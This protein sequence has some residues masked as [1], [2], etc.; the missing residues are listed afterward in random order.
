MA[1]RDE[2]LRALA[3]QLVRSPTAAALAVEVDSLDLERLSVPDTR[4]CR[5]AE[6]VCRAACSRSLAAHCFR[7]YAWAALL[8][9]GLEWD[10]EMLYT[11]AI[12]HDLGL[13]PDYDRGGCF[14]SDGAYAAREI[15]TAVGWT[16]PRLDTVAEAVYLHMH[17]VTSAHSAEARLLA[18]GTAADVTGRRIL[19]LPEG[20]RRFVLEMF[21]RAGFKQEL[22]VRFTEQA[23]WK[24]RCVIYE[25]M[26]NGLAD[27][28]AAAPFDE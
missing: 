12:L 20:T 8:G 7:S 10:E 22:I 24:P 19:E 6:R 4:A 5:E 16:S 18:A 21:P 2:T 17:E 11:A 14:E 1:A 25:Y 28:I 26:R 23:R 3:T 9:D 27:R 15:L 13:T